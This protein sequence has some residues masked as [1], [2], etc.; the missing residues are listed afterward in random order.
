[1]RNRGSLANPQRLNVRWRNRDS[2]I[3][4]GRALVAVLAI[5]GLLALGKANEPVYGPPKAP[6]T[7]HGVR[8]ATDVERLTHDLHQA[9][10]LDQVEQNGW[11]S[12]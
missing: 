6:H 1:M 5:A 2:A 7:I 3:M 4:A 12:N 10:E 9:W 8:P 11:G